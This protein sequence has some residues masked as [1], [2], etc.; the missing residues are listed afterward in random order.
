MQPK[1][2]VPNSKSIRHTYHHIHGDE[3]QTLKRAPGTPVPQ[4]TESSYVGDLELTASQKQ[5]NR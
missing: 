5:V 3:G 4:I 1:G 2:K